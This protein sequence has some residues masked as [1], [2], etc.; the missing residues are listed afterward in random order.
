MVS[1]RGCRPARGCSG[2][3]PAPRRRGLPVAVATPLVVV[4]WIN[5]VMQL[6]DLNTNPWLQAG[7]VVVGFLLCVAGGVAIARTRK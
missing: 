4:L 5:I 7:L 1:L 6:G 2:P 3:P